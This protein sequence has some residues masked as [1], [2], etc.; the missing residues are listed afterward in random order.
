MDVN[1]N[2]ITSKT[3]ATVEIHVELKTSTNTKLAS[4]AP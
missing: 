1:K 3:N 2:R 4:R